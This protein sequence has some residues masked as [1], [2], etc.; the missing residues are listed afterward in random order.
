MSELSKIDQWVE[1]YKPLKGL[2]GEFARLVRNDLKNLLDKIGLNYQ[3]ATCREKSEDSLRDKLEAKQKAEK[4]IKTLTKIND[5][6]GCRIIFYLEMDIE[7]IKEHLR[8]EFEIIE[9]ELKYSP[10][11]YN[12]YH[13]TVKL[14]KDKAK[15]NGYI[16]FNDL[17]C[18]IQLTTVLYHAWSELNHNIIYKPKNGILEFDKLKTEAIKERFSKVMKNHIKP[19]QYD[20]ESISGEVEKIKQVKKVFNKVEETNQAREVFNTVPLQNIARLKT[21]NEIYQSLES[22]LTCLREFRDKTLKELDIIKIINGVLKRSKPPKKESIKNIPGNFLDYDYIDIA[23]I[24]LGILEHLKFLYPKEIFKILCQLSIE[25]NY[26]I[27][28]RALE[29]AAEIAEYTFHPEKEIIYFH[30]Q[31]IILDEIEKLDDRSLL[32]YLS[33]LTTVSS[34]MLSPSFEGVSQDD[35]ETIGIHQGSLPAGDTVKIIRQRTLNFLKKLYALSE[36]ISDKV[37]IIKALDEATCTPNTQD[38]T[39]KLEKIILTNTNDLIAYYTSIITEADNEIIRIIDRQLYWFK[40]RFPTGLI[41][42]EKLESLIEKNKEYSI[43]KVLVGSDYNPEL[44]YKEDQK[45]RDQK[46]DEYIKQINEQNFL[47]W[48]KRILSIA[49]IYELYTDLSLFSYFN[50]FLQEL[51]KQKPEI[52]HRLI[53]QNEQELKLSLLNLVVGI[54]QSNKK[55]QAKKV[56]GNWID[57]GKHLPVCARLFEYAEEIDEPLLNKV[58]QKAKEQNDIEAIRYTISSIVS[59]YEQAKIGK[60]L[61][62]SCI[63][64]LSKNKNYRWINLV[65]FRGDAILETLDKNDWGTVLDNLLSVPEIDYDI[66]R[67]LLTAAKNVP[68]KLISFFHERL[69]IQKE[70]KQQKERYDAIPHSLSELNAPLSKN[71]GVVIEEVLKWFE[72]DDWLP[73]WEVGHFLQ[74]IFPTFHPELEQQ[75]IKLL[76]STNKNKAN[77]VFYILR[78][79]KGETFL[80]DTCKAFI[81]QYPKNKEHES[82]MFLILSQLGVVSGEYGMVEAYKIKKQEI[83]AWKTDEDKVIRDFV[84]QYENDLSQLITYEQKR[85]DEDIEIR[86]REFEWRHKQTD[87]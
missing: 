17:K 74:I 9:Q 56:L 36:T 2:Y 7:K 86:K 24:S 35:Y 43:Y 34:Q 19:A 48:Q 26:R 76:K 79:Y 72:Q 80:H 84:E 45:E 82:N 81:K 57:K 75:L 47:L 10:D 3:V 39:P 6:A 55:E 49:E 60:D 18:E 16:K 68:K 38:C 33:L 31:L 21:N 20:F 69:N 12:A 73:Y 44:D 28:K 37:M 50:F 27:K 14:G 5:L 53:L 77:I 61:F 52:S 58:Y 71:A 8:T 40:K 54:W 42:L 59:N 64:E 62:I 85:A 1:E 87:T 4:T 63:K 78:S 70:K 15:L 67:I 29:V 65:W 25:D 51:G 41:N 32:T 66:E 23:I 30:A 22:L 83:Q 46:I 11:G 13:L